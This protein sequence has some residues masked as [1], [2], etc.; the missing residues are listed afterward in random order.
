MGAQALFFCDSDHGDVSFSRAIGRKQCINHPVWVL[1]KATPPAPGLVFFCFLK[2]PEKIQKMKMVM[3]WPP[4]GQK[5]VLT[6]QFCIIL[7]ILDHREYISS[8][9][10][11]QLLLLMQFLCNFWASYEKNS[12]RPGWDS[13]PQRREEQDTQ[14]LWPTHY[15]TQ[16]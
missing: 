1:K 2:F 11:I 7:Q 12:K 5:H 3:K 13:N 9:T 16:I 6:Q 15:R 10:V 4:S 8:V 14:V